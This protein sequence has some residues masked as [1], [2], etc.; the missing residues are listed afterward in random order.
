MLLAFG[1]RF[2]PVAELAG[3]ELRDQRQCRVLAAP[4]QVDDQDPPVGADELQ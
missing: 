1:R 4:R 3:A 2:G